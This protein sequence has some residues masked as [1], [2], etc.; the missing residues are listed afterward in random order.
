MLAMLAYPAAGKTGVTAVSQTP[1]LD[2]AVPAVACQ[3]RHP[4]VGFSAWDEENGTSGNDTELA[5]NH[6]AANRGGAWPTTA[7]AT[8]FTAPCKGLYVFSFSFERD[9]TGLCGATTGTTDDVT[10]YL[11]KNGTGIGSMEAWAGES[12]AVR[13]SAAASAVL[14]LVAGDQITSWVRSD[15]G[16][17]RC[18]A[19][20]DFSGYLVSP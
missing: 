10:M 13:A 3:S 4:K 17:F 5:Y 16:K 19:L 11:R 14:F 7:S 6:V 20:Y 15:G 2:D 12:D 18:L 1:F 9:A 8:T